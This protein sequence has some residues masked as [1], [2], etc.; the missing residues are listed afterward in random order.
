MEGSISRMRFKHGC[1]ARSRV[2]REACNH[3]VS[4]SRRGVSSVLLMAAL[5]AVAKPV[6]RKVRR[7][8]LLISKR[9]TIRTITKRGELSPH[10]HD[11]AG[12]RGNRKGL[13]ES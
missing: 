6:K 7:S 2:L 5:K 10:F 4:V 3:C 11:G 9:V 13:Q 1:N 8:S 12:S